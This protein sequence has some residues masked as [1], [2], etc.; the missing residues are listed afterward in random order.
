LRTAYWLSLYFIVVFVFIILWICDYFE[1]TEFEKISD[2]P[3]DELIFWTHAIFWG[4][5]FAMFLLA[6]FSFI[7]LFIGLFSDNRFVKQKDLN[8]NKQTVEAEFKT[9]VSVTENKS[10][11]EN[12]E[13]MEISKE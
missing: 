3:Y 12:Q 6:V 7:G 2:N 13:E 10:I 11:N 9:S 4:H 1:I 5:I 8:E